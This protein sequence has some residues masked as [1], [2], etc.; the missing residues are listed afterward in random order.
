[1]FCDIVRMLQVWKIE[2]PSDHFDVPVSHG[3]AL[4]ETAEEAKLLSGHENAEIEQKPEHM[5]VA[6]ERVIWENR[7]RS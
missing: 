1:M 2:I 3:W 6:R 5:W 4:A 7:N